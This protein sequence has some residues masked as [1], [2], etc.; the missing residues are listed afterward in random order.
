MIDFLEFLSVPHKR[1]FIYTLWLAKK[2]KK[3]K[4][5]KCPNIFG[6]ISLAF[7]KTLEW[8]Y[9]QSK[10]SAVPTSDCVIIILWL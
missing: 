5:E 6:Y 1:N 9:D 7:S 2:K 4:P 8:P 10:I 3:K